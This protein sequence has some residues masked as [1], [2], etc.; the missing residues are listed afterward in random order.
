MK[1]E[2]EPNEIDAMARDIVVSLG[3]D[4]NKPPIYLKDR[5]TAEVLGVKT[6]TLGIWRCTGR[7]DL[8]YIKTGRRPV[9]PLRGVARFLLAQRR[10]GH[11]DARK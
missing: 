7:H 5:E 10:F 8:E 4:P 2:I 11:S 1:N 3:L 6:T 9:Y